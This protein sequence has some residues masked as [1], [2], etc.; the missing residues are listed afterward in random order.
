MGEREAPPYMGR[1]RHLLILGGGGTS[2]YGEEEAPTYMGRLRHLL[3]LGGAGTSL[4]GEGQAPPYMG[5][6]R[7]LYVKMYWYA[8]N[9]FEIK[10]CQQKEKD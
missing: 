5:R 3:I 10:I 4:Y 8:A 2:L 1:K 9:L 7:H 6:G